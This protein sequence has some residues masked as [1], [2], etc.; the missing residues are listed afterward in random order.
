MLAGVILALRRLNLV[1]EAVIRPLA[2][3]SMTLMLF[4]VL[5]T[6]VARETFL[7]LPWTDKVSLILLPVLAFIVAPV[8]YR[9]SE[10]VALDLFLD[11]LPPKVARLHALLIH[12]CLAVVFLIGLDLTL[13]KI[14]LRFAPLEILIETVFRLDVS[15]I[16]PFKAPLRIPTIGL[17]WRYVY[18][19]MPVSFALL[20]LANLEIVLRLILGLVRP[21]EPATTPVRTF[22]EAHAGVHH[23]E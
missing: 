20:L 15:S 13:R 8:A 4:A 11:V 7:F 22:D 2:W 1:V 12:L 10:N 21:N 3:V 5:L 9:R 16:R 6:V 18:M 17:E 23:E 14:G 19:V